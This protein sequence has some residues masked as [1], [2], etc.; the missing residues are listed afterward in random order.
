MLYLP[1]PLLKQTI[2]KTQKRKAGLYR[3][4]NRKRK[5]TE[6]E[7]FTQGFHEKKYRVENRNPYLSTTTQAVG[8]IWSLKR[9]P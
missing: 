3:P 9:S 6:E 7:A 5:Q 4:A 2:S 1:N 8:S